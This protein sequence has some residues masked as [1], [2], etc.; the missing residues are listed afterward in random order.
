MVVS[1]DGKGGVRNPSGVVCGDERKRTADD[2]S[3]CDQDDVK[4]GDVPTSRDESGSNLFPGQTASGME[5]ALPCIGLS[6]G[7]WEPV[8]AMLRENAE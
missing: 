5:A 4:T 1:V 2:V 6:C 7:T 3:K 8:V